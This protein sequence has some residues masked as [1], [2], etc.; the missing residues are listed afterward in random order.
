MHAHELRRREETY[1]N[2][3]YRQGG[4]GSNSCGPR[5]LP[6]YLLM[7]EPMSFRVRLRPFAIA[8]AGCVADAVRPLL[9]VLE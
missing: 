5:P 8:P 1:L 3:D 6:Q 7:P 2:L 4:L 9:T